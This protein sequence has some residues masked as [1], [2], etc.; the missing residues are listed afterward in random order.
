MGAVTFFCRADGKTPQEAFESARKSALGMYGNDGCTGSIAEKSKFILIEL[1]EGV[2]PM[3]YAD[4]LIDSDDARV[5]D[6]WGPAGCLKYSK[7][8]FLFFG[9]ASC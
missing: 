7:D 3:D 4:Q 5:S 1:P 2:K 9:W 8:N 6:K